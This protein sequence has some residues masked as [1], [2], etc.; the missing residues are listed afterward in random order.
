MPERAPVPGQK[1]PDFQPSRRILLNLSEGRYAR[2]SP[3]DRDSAAHPGAAD[4]TP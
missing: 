1:A 4:R 2:R 3:L